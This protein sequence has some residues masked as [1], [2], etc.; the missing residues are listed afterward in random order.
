LQLLQIQSIL[1]S[2]GVGAAIICAISCTG[3]GIISAVDWVAKRLS[4]VLPPQPKQQIG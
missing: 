4:E 2:M 1:I 3:V